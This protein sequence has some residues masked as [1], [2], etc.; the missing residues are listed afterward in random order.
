MPADAKAAVAARLREA[1]TML[2]PTPPFAHEL[3]LGKIDV[4][5][6]VQKLNVAHW[7]AKGRR[8]IGR[9]SA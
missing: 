4:A 2:R 8:Q 9:K 5:Y 3:G 1:E 7:R 6:D